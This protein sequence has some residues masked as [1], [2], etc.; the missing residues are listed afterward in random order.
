MH[1][2]SSPSSFDLPSARTLVL[3]AAAACTAS[4]A[5][6]S[7]HR[8]MPRPTR[9]PHLPI[10]PYYICQLVLTP[11]TPIDLRCL[12]PKQRPRMMNIIINYFILTLLMGIFIID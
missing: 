1:S 5:R 8:H 6:T 12:V 4:D 7:I 10:S 2:P 3:A 9:A 11:S